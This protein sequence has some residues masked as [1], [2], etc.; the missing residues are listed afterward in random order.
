MQ[1]ETLRHC[2]LLT[3]SFSFQS[4]E[5]ENHTKI[6]QLSAV[7]AGSRMEKRVSVLLDDKEISP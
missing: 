2:V 6:F 5:A 1:K 4:R 7:R 3:P